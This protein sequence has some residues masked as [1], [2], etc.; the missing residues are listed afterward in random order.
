MALIF[1]ALH[2]PDK[3]QLSQ[4]MQVVIVM[5]V[6][7]WVDLVAKEMTLVR[8]CKK[9]LQILVGLQYYKINCGFLFWFIFL[10]SV[11]TLY[12]VLSSLLFYGV[13]LEMTYFRT[14]LVQ[15]AVS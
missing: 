1:S 11:Y 2:T 7:G 5:M 14:D 10:H 9:K 3:I 12:R 13:T 8:F 15:Q 4:T 6:M